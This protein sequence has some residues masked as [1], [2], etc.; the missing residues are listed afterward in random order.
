M[1]YP[2]E[3]M[4]LHLSALDLLWRKFPNL[5]GNLESLNHFLRSLG[6]TLQ[7]SFPPKLCQTCLRKIFLPTGMPPQIV[8]SEASSTRL[9]EADQTPRQDDSDLDRTVAALN[10][11]IFTR[12]S[13]PR[14]LEEI[15]METLLLLWNYE[16]GECSM[17][18]TEVLCEQP[19]EVS[20]WEL[21]M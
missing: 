9:A 17:C 6:K 4:N 1:I 16:E 15:T 13:S 19:K 14:D 20:P 3:L 12:L 7:S 10:V 5:K 2:E 21:E 18:D 8:P 11:Y